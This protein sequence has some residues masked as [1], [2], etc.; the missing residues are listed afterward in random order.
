MVIFHSYVSSPKGNMQQQQRDA[1]GIWNGHLPSVPGAFVAMGRA[2][3]F[4]VMLRKSTSM[5][6]GSTGL[7]RCPWRY[8]LAAPTSCGVHPQQTRQPKEKT[9]Q[10]FS[11]TFKSITSSLK[12]ITWFPDSSQ[13]GISPCR[14]KNHA[15]NQIAN[16]CGM[17]SVCSDVQLTST[18]LRSTVRS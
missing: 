6:E 2:L 13:I 9:K 10:S 8:S 4:P 16:P 14:R 12:R 17:C 5:W 1:V 3:A 18:N 7:V 15:R 11:S